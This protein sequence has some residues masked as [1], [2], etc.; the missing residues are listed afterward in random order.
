MRTLL[1]GLATIAI[2]AVFA[3]GM[4]AFRNREASTAACTATLRPGDDV[5]AALFRAAAGATVCLEAGTHR[6]ISTARVRPDVTLIGAGPDQTVIRADGGSAVEIVDVERF[7]LADLSVRGGDPAAVYI[8]R[9][10]DAN[11]R[12]IRLGPAAFGLHIENGA[13]VTATDT[14]IA[15]TSD[16][17]VLL[18]RGGSAI[19]DRLRV[20]DL[21]GIGVGAVD[22]PGPL[23]I[24]DAEVVRAGPTAKGEGIVLNGR[25]RFALERVV[26][27]GGD[28]AGIYVA[29]AGELTLRDVQ[30]E[31]ANFGLHLDFNANAIAENVTLAGSTGVA[32]L[33]QRGG[34][35]DARA[36]RILD[37]A[38]T[39][40]SAINGAGLVTLRDSQ[41]SRVA[42]AGLFAG[43]AGCE[44]LPPASLDV[45]ACFYEN[46]DERIST[47]RVKL[48]RVQIDGTRGPCLVF[49]PGV[50]ADIR[51]STFTHCELTG[52]FAWGAVADF[53]RSTF[54]NNAEHALEYRAFPDPRGDVIAPASG[55]IEDSIF[56]RT[57]PLEGEILGALGP[58]P[59]LGGGILAQGSRLV[60]RRNDVSDNRDIGISFVNRSTGEVVENRITG[61]GNYGLCLLPGTAVSVQNN[62]MTGNRSDSL[63]V[64]GGQ[65]TS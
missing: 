55:T 48:E 7:T 14:A 17:G 47:I 36:L 25:Q 23:T 19:F 59:V 44:D 31:S 53:H 51:D 27:R 9:A 40:I 54:E 15:E 39:G 11:L 61:N 57:R 46:L 56:R 8:A 2:V 63:T 32:L 13:T 28:P 1:T 26:V 62:T 10:R 34:T 20:Q 4:M 16:F 38:G 58:G 37:A 45:P 50:H 5:T 22:D 12:N 24:R 6:P 43:V 52:L 42:A 64:C 35:I 49:F 41:I 65:P 21:R 30:V 60:L 33:L 3:A 29:R 18:R